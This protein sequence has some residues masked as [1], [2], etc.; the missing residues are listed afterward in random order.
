M[1]PQTSETEPANLRF[2][3]RLVTAL[4]ATM[5]VGLVAIVGLLVINLGRVSPA[6]AT[7]D[8]LAIPENETA[9]AF[10]QGDGWTALVTRD[11]D[12]TERIRIFTPD[13]EEQQVV[14]IETD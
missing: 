9:Q 7:P 5:I 12:G 8:T 6:P 4:T 3:R 1:D 10:T 11:T 13:G 2:L 14:T